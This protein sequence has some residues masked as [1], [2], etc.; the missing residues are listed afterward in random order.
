MK[1][2]PE[3]KGFVVTVKAA[4]STNGNGKARREPPKGSLVFKESQGDYS[5]TTAEGP[6]D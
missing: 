2:T 1:I 6:Q 4:K 3:N 5:L